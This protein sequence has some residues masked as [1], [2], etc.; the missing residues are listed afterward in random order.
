M[1]VKA[2]IFDMDGTLT[3]PFLDFD[4]IRREMGI[5]KECGSVLEA[6][7]AMP[8]SERQKATE[9]L[10][11]HEQEA[12]RHSRLNPGVPETLEALRRRFLKLGILTRN[13]LESTKAVLEKH[14]LEFDGIVT[15]E[16]GP[17]K[18]DAF[19][20]VYLCKLF[21]TVPREALVVGD[22]LHDLLTARNAGARSVLLKTHREAKRFEEFADFSIDR[23]E[24]V[25]E[26]ID[27]I[28]GNHAEKHKKILD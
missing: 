26:I 15:R 3:E 28:K 10:L 19:G 16:T 22:F 5:A 1:S 11:R 14:F 8:L 24:E 23:I 25:V 18:P 12:A 6:L 9:I 27:T 21:G 13:S 7:S 17:V 2:V 4:I 20:V